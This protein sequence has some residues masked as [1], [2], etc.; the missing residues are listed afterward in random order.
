[1][2]NKKNNKTSLTKKV[3]KKAASKKAPSK[4]AFLP[5]ILKKDEQVNIE[6]ETALNGRYEI[7]TQN[8]SSSPPEF[9]YYVEL[10][11]IELSTG[12]TGV[13]YSIFNSNKTWSEPNKDKLRMTL[14]YTDNL[15]V[16]NEKLKPFSRIIGDISEM[17]CFYALMQVIYYHQSASKS[18]NFYAEIVYND[19]KVIAKY[20]IH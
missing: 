12:I 5:P 16:L 14:I 19:R 4:R 13:K 2:S 6:V 7:L 3:F 1:M 15:E 8:H 11:E 18:H 20:K 17:D 9:E 10:S